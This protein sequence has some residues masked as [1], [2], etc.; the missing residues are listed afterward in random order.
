MSSYDFSTYGNMS[1]SYGDMSDYSDDDT[2]SE[3]LEYERKMELEKEINEHFEFNNKIA[4]KN[5]IME[6][7]FDDMWGE[8]SDE[9][10]FEEPQQTATTSKPAVNFVQIAAKLDEDERTAK[11]RVP[12][13]RNLLEEMDKMH[14]DEH[15]TLKYER[16]FGSFRNDA[17][18]KDYIQF[19]WRQLWARKKMFMMDDFSVEKPTILASML[20]RV[21]HRKCNNMNNM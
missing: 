20:N 12:S 11:E 19:Y 3:R 9:E 2:S 17:D 4:Q 16:E 15:I 1:D 7:V 14:D 6:R 13:Y 10:H 18:K 21:P 8:K 5:T